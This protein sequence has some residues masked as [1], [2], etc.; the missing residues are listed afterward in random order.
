VQEAARG[1]GE[2][3]AN[4]GGVSQAAG[5]TSAAASQVQAASGEVARQGEMLK[6]EI[7]RFLTDVRAA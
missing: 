7:D 2:V 1:T 3:S 6:A 5:E 4:I